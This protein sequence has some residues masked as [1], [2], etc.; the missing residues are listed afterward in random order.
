[1]NL[2]VSSLLSS[3]R[4]E[5]TIYNHKVNGPLEEHPCMD[6]RENSNSDYDLTL[7]VIV[8]SHTFP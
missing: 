1:M 7:C 4:L 8:A 5:R 3:I 2:V 6:S